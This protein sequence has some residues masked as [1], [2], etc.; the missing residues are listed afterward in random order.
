MENETNEDFFR[1]LQCHGWR[2]TIKDLWRDPQTSEEDK[3]WLDGISKRTLFKFSEQEKIKKLFEK[4][5]N[6]L[7]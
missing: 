6:K 1:A 2:G 4:N 5:S 3:S 7:P